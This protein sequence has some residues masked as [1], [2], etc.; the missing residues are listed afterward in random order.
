MI[1]EETELKGAYIIHI[2]KLEDD[3]GF[4]ARAWCKKEFEKHQLNSQFV[5]TNIASSIKKGTL[6]GLHYQVSPH[7]E[8]KL[9]RCTKGEIFDVI[10]DLR[11]KSPTYMKW[12]GFELKADND[13]MLYV[14]EN[15]A[16]GYLTFTD[17]VEVFYH[18]SQFYSQE[19]EHGIRWNDPAFGIEWPLTDELVISEKDKTYTRNTVCR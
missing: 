10:V 4:F 1:F 17:N 11:P 15:F 9:V 3:R 8:A 19:S 16:H 13:T 12:M 14:P 2:E 7:E 18:V 5:Q 6:R